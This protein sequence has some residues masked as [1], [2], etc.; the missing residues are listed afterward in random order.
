MA[1]GAQS[2]RPDPARQEAARA[3]I[4]THHDIDITQSY[5]GISAETVHYIDE[6]QVTLGIEMQQNPFP[7]NLDDDLARSLENNTTIYDDQIEDLLA[8]DSL[9]LNLLKQNQS[10]GRSRAIRAR[11]SVLVLSILILK[12]TVFDNNAGNNSAHVA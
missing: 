10:E 3:E 8:E 9:Y 12:G 5:T 2:Y 1:V 11:R 7:H 4:A 6:F